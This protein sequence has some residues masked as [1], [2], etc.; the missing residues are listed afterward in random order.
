MP[1]PLSLLPNNI[2]I[3]QENVSSALII[4][5]QQCIGIFLNTDLSEQLIL[6]EYKRHKKF[7]RDSIRFS[8]KTNGRT[9]KRM[10][11]SLSRNSYAGYGFIPKEFS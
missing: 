9:A 2:V 1:I 10:P 6:N 3:L 7:K 5:D 8:H 11:L 4:L